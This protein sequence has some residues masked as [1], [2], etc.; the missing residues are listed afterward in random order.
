MP[1]RGHKRFRGSPELLRSP[2]RVAMLEVERVTALAL[3]GIEALKILDAGTGSG[4][5]AGAFRRQAPFVVGLDLS[6]P[7]LS[8]ARRILSEVFFV[9]GDLEALPFASGAFDLIF[10]GHVLHEV[11]DLSQALS[12]LKRCARK[13][14][15]ALEWPYRD[16]P[17][18][19][20]LSHRLP[21]ELVLRTAR[22]V[23]FTGAEIILLKRM[24][25]YRL[26]LPQD[27]LT[28]HGTSSSPGFLQ[29]VKHGTNTTRPASG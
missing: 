1:E 27:G 8:E 19:P 9:Q 21:P 24:V 3:E 16:E 13:R 4:L 28:G 11:D 5:F 25:L 12:E 22:E 2:H 26:N 10:L 7:I 17:D 14:V 23:G 20:P 29:E 18:G 15:V 6:F